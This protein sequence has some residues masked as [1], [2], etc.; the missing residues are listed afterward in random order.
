VS[1]P[2]DIWVPDGAPPLAAPN[3]GVFRRLVDD[4]EGLR[5]LVRLM[6]QPAEERRNTPSELMTTLT[7]RFQVYEQ[8]RE[9]ALYTL[10][11]ERDQTRELVAESRA[12]GKAVERALEALRACEPDSEAWQPPFEELQRR[13]DAMITHEEERL[14]PTAR[15]TLSLHQVDRLGEQYDRAREQAEARLQQRRS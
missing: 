6:G 3:A 11:A 12:R 2:D 1:A 5:T 10:L 8:A 14:V 4:H 7:Q 13:M 9:H 15:D